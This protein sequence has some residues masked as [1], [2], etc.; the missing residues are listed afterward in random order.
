ME[1]RPFEDGHDDILRTAM[2]LN[3]E[4]PLPV[5]I[6]TAYWDLVRTFRRIHETVTQKDLAWLVINAGRATPGDPVTILDA[7]KD[8]R[9]ARDTKVLAY[10]RGEWRAARYQG[11]KG[12]KVY[13]IIDGD[14]AEE[15][16]FAATELRVPSRDELALVET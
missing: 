12:K 13:A 2:K 3:V 15:R 14:K 11:K 16:E 8:G 5:T 4:D 9:V 6:V 1:V 7:V 10:W